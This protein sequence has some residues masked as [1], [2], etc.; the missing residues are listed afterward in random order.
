MVNLIK[1]GNISL[2]VLETD[3]DIFADIVD[4]FSNESLKK[5]CLID[6]DNYIVP[7]YFKNKMTIVILID[8]KVEGYAIFE[9]K[10]GNNISQVEIKNMYISDKYKNQNAEL[11]LIEGVV[12][13]AGE[14]GTRNVLVTIKESE[15]NNIG[16]YQAFGF[17]EIGMNEE[18]ILLNANVAGL[19]TKRKLFDK[20]RSFPKDALDY[21]SLKIVKKLAASSSGSV[22]LTKDGKILKMFT[23]PSFIYIKDR[24]ETLKYI[25]TLDIE[26]IVKPK[27]LVYYDGVFVGYIM[28][29]LPEG[30][31]L[32]INNKIYS[33]EEKI[34][35]IK[36]IEEVMKKLHKKHVFMC[37]L[38][39][40]NIFF[41]KD[42]KVKLINC[43]SF[44]IKNNVINSDV[45]L[46]YQDPLN[47]VVS[48]KT[49]LYAFSIAI[50]QL[51]TNTKINKKATFNEVQKIY[52]KN[53]NKLPV[54]FKAYYEYIF[55]GSERYYLTEAYEKYLNEIYNDSEEEQNNKKSGKISVIILS[56]ILLVIAVLGYVVFKFIS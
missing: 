48:E 28:D 47:K 40:D 41:D 30:E 13:I 52:I 55:N 4:T 23:S 35:K 24:E 8:K 29:Y 45:P 7:E 44:V 22:Y 16:T 39:L 26:E 56:F 20:F 3:F 9:F 46:K 18:G 14:V 19:I 42:G 54:S 33:F 50:L 21:R 51:L 11:L 34:D 32:S 27:N 17:Y 5:E 43:D 10:S 31:P 25:K 6:L 12:Y 2:E 1:K 15:N 53:K 49:D 37:D 36:A 38:S